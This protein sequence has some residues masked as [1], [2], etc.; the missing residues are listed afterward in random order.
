MRQVEL[1]D[2]FGY[3]PYKLKVIYEHSGTATIKVINAEGVIQLCEKG[4][5]RKYHILKEIERCKPILRPRSD[6]YKT[7]THNGKEIIPIVELAK[8]VSPELGFDL[9]VE[10]SNEIYAQCGSIERIFYNRG[11]FSKINGYG[12]VSAIENQHQLFDYLHELKIDYRGL[13]DSGLAIDANT[14]EVNPYK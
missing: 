11:I 14:L 2:I 3:L 13:I 4:D 5:W 9:Y 8:M 1:K 6:L 10:N 7:I 12:H